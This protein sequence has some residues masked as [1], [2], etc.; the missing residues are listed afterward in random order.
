M[1]LAILNGLYASMKLLSLN[2][3]WQPDEKSQ[4]VPMWLYLA[5]F[6]QDYAWKLN[7]SCQSNYGH[8][9]MY[10]KAAKIFIH[11][12]RGNPFPAG[13][14]YIQTGVL[15]SL[16]LWTSQ[17]WRWKAVSRPDMKGFSEW[18]RT[19][20]P[21]PQWVISKHTAIQCTHGCVAYAACSFY[22]NDKNCSL[23]E[24]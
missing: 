13:S 6:S 4:L 15:S 19:S 14:V 10:V 16:R 7:F 18:E 3:M 1:P 22:S 8:V 12:T 23:Y 11:I 21:E 24:Y 9:A 5:V 20:L 2:V 17:A